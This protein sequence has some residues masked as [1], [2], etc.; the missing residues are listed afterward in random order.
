MILA[1]NVACAQTIEYLRML[2]S[3]VEAERAFARR[4][5]EIGA[6]P[7][8]LEFFADDAIVFRPQ[9]V[10]YKEA[11]KSAPAQSNPLATTLSWEP[12]FADVSVGGDLGYTTG[13]AVW[14]DHTPAK[15]PARYS[16][17]FSVWKKQDAG[18]WKVVF[19]VGT[20]QTHLY[21]GS[22]VLQ[23]PA[24]RGKE[25]AELSQSTDDHIRSLMRAE[26]EFLAVLR[27]KGKANALVQ[28]AGVDVRIYREKTAPLVG[29]DAIR[30]F[31]S[32]HQYMNEWTAEFCDVARAG[33]MGYVYGSYASGGSADAM[34]ALEKGYYMRVWKRD[35][36]NIWRIAA[37]VTSPM[38]VESPKAGQ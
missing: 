27:E 19:D 17:Y 5:L 18:G 3:L 12:L 13:P 22:R 4:S 23:S 37:E 32:S 31:F 15:R 1:A 16:Y 29:I 24:V 38:P 26:G 36:L 34:D 8:F 20:E 14:T 10:K 28:S 30:E 25:V 35:R 6:R 21:S 33:D 7:A 9:P 2:S 11:M